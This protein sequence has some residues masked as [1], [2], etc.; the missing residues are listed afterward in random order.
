MSNEQW[1]LYTTWYAKAQ[2]LLRDRGLAYNYGLS[3][4]TAARVI[5]DGRLGF[6]HISSFGSEA[7]RSILET[8]RVNV[9]HGIPTAIQLPNRPSDDAVSAEPGMTATHEFPPY[10]FE[11]L[12]AVHPQVRESYPNATSYNLGISKRWVSVENSDGLK[13]WESDIRWTL[14]ASTDGEEVF[15]F[16]PDPTHILKEEAVEEGQVQLKSGGH[17]LFI[18]AKAAG[19]LL[20]PHLSHWMVADWTRGRTPRW[21]GDAYIGVRD[22]PRSASWFSRTFDDEGIDCRS[23]PLVQGGRIIAQLAS[24]ETIH[25]EHAVAA[26]NGF[27]ASYRALPRTLPR[28]LVLEFGLRGSDPPA[29]RTLIEEVSEVAYEDDYDRFV[30]ICGG[31]HAGNTH[32]EYRGS[33]SDILKSVVWSGEHTATVRGAFTVTSPSFIAIPQ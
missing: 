4:G 19:V 21:A 6:A 18:G 26:G 5:R 30:A 31:N 23:A 24:L 13:R 12:E 14:E 15:R 29:C 10:I 17:G 3:G 2:I 32:F 9:E 33:A 22:D 27:R 1:D 20:G 7:A 16:G 28:N 25:F 8:A 11:M